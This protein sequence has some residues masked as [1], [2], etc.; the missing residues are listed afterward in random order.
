MC[1]SYRDI[2]CLLRIVNLADSFQSLSEDE[3][4]PALR[5]EVAHFDNLVN[6]RKVEASSAMLVF[7]N[8]A[9]FKPFSPAK[10]KLSK[11]FPDFGHDGD[12]KQAL[13]IRA[14]NMFLAVNRKGDPDKCI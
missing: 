8:L 2:P 11:Q 10:E 9:R 1:T 6:S 12:T 4:M 5:E 14:A 7:F 3:S 13:R